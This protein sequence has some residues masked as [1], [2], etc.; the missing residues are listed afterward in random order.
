MRRQWV[1]TDIA[2]EDRVES[3]MSI[4]TKEWKKRGQP[5]TTTRKHFASQPPLK[6]KARGRLGSKM[7]TTIMQRMTM[8]NRQ[9]AVII[10]SLHIMSTSNG[11]EA[12]RNAAGRQ[13]A[14]LNHYGRERCRRHGKRP[15]SE[16]KV[17]MPRNEHFALGP[18]S[19][20]QSI[21]KKQ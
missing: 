20:L 15:C 21:M 17:S 10:L 1:T 9:M 3:P 18:L 12:A 6:S 5:R 14:P 4:I 16:T 8:S 13:G 7:R 2:A 11:D 19:R